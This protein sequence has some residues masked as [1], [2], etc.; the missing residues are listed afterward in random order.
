MDFAAILQT[1]KNVLT[2]PGEPV[3]EQERIKPTATFTTAI[4]WIVIAAVITAVLGL[5]RGLIFVS[6]GFMEQ[7]IGRMNLPPDVTQQM[8]TMLSRGM[9]GGMMGGAG[10]A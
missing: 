6:S 10:L 5:L 7:M 8:N 3:F 2:Q 9:L 1:W 4:I